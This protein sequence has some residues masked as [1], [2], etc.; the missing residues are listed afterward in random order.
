MFASSSVVS[1]GCGG[2]RL[3]AMS[4]H[5]SI[6]HLCSQDTTTVATTSQWFVYTGYDDGTDATMNDRE[7]STKEEEKKTKSSNIMRRNE[8]SC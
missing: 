7:S 8:E 4:L 3:S 6:L 1:A 2:G 5:I